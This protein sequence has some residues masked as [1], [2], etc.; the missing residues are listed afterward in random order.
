MLG[1]EQDFFEAI[2]GNHV[3]KQYI[4]NYQG[5]INKSD[6]DDIWSIYRIDDDD[7]DDDGEGR[8]AGA[9]LNPSNL[10]SLRDL[11][12]RET[13][14][15]AENAA[16]SFYCIAHSHLYS[17]LAAPRGLRHL[18]KVLQ[19]TCS[20]LK[21]I[22]ELG[23]NYGNLRAENMVVVMR[24]DGQEIEGVRFI[25]FGHTQEIGSS[26]AEHL[27]VPE[28]IDHLAPEEL[29]RLR[30]LLGVWEEGRKESGDDPSLSPDNN[31][32]ASYDVFSL[33]ILLLQIVVGC[34]TQLELPIKIRC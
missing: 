7:D 28:D 14:H 6:L 26:S 24:E 27:I 32:Q 16:D 20:F 30:E 22:E 17:L 8:S 9:A 11:L 23:L 18:A 10:I 31:L 19:L 2:G 29:C 1:R 4:F 25:N 13:V 34:P 3:L 21:E 15:F 5:I 33:G 12:F